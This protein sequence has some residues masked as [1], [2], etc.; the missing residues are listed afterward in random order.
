MRNPQLLFLDI[1]PELCEQKFIKDVQEIGKKNMVSWVEEL[2]RAKSKHLFGLDNIW[3][4][5]QGELQFWHTHIAL[6]ECVWA[7]VCTSQLCPEL[8]D[9]SFASIF[10]QSALASFSVEAMLFLRVCEAKQICIA[11]VALVA[12]KLQ[13]R[14]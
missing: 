1:S 8:T 4:V 5:C 7:G 11:C 13:V 14:E 6:R 3:C 10:E 2:I 12:K 9:E